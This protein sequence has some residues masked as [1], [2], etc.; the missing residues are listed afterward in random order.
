MIPVQKLLNRIRWDEEYAKSDYLIGYYDRSEDRIIRIRFRELAFPPD[1][2]F[3][4][5][6]MDE[7]GELHDV[8]YHRV[9]EVYR[10][11]VLIW[12]REH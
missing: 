8:P 12:H 2:H 6:L 4:F 1:D 10:D 5:Q 3:S 9:K 11:G 7:E